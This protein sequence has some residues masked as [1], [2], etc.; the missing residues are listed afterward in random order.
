MA[1]LRVRIATGNARLIRESVFPW[2][3]RCNAE[4]LGEGYGGRTVLL[5][6]TD[7]LRSM[8]YSRLQPG[9]IAVADSGAHTLAY[10]GRDTWIEADPDRATGFQV[11]EVSV[12]N[13]RNVW[14]DLPMQIL[15]WKILA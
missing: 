12:A 7:S 5:L 11:I 14:L 4:T 6:D 15:R 2:S 1:T 10:I 9:D 13:G 8:N 3:H